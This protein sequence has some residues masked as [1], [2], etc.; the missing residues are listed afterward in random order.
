MVWGARAQEAQS[1]EAVRESQQA[2]RSESI[3]TGAVQK[4]TF[5]RT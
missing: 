1:R 4:H 2:V 3:L 5:T